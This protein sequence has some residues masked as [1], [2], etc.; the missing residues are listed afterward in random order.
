MPAIIETLDFA[1]GLRTPFKTI[2]M[3]DP[4]GLVSLNVRSLSADGQQ[5]AVSFSKKI[6]T[7]FVVT[8]AK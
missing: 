1:T 6:S 7:L 8:Q 5:Y 4:T 2:G 3:A